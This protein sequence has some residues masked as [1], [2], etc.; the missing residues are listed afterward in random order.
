MQRTTPPP[1]PASQWKPAVVVPI[2]ASILLIALLLIIIWSAAASWPL[3]GS[4]REPKSAGGSTQR[5]D[6]EGAGSSATSGLGKGEDDGESESAASP[7]GVGGHSNTPSMQA[8]ET[9]AS[10]GNE[11]QINHP[12]TRDEGPAT[13]PSSPRSY[14][15]FTQ[16]TGVSRAAEVIEPAGREADFFGIAAA[17]KRFV[18]VVDKSS[19]MS[20]DRFEMARQELL[21]SLNKLKAN[22]SFFVIFYDDVA[23]PQ[24]SKKLT[25]ARASNVRRMSAWV[26]N[27]VT[28]GGTSPMD[29]IERAISF[30]P[31]AVYI[32]SDG[33]FDD[34]VVHQTAYLNDDSPIKIHTIGFQN[35]AA[36]LREIAE[37]NGGSYRFI[38]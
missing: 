38:P 8:A 33:E 12:T 34:S 16:R 24:P 1:L 11:E 36:T 17:G 37:Q 32:L 2:I 30:E 5:R 35:D 6:S 26:K 10:L 21:R 4:H 7:T 18:Y 3:N 20:G 14:E 29:A 27:A 23:Y 19:S 13:V 28:Q 9:T 15:F 31:D 22:Q 25:P